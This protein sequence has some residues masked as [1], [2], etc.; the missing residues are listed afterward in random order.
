MY[1]YLYF[2]LKTYKFFFII[3]GKKQSIMLLYLNL[4]NKMFINK[5]TLKSEKIIINLR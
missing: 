2:I 1:N 4:Y 3:L 5:K